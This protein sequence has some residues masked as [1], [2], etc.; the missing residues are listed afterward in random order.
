MKAHAERIYPH[1][2]CGFLLGPDLWQ[3]HQVVPATNEWGQEE[4][5]H[6]FIITA[7]AARRAE[8]A[9]KKA[10]LSIIGHYH[11]HPD[12]PARPSSGF[13]DSDLDSATWPGFAFVIVSVMKGK[14]ADVTCWNLAEDRSSFEAV[15]TKILNS[16][17][18]TRSGER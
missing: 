17:V 14:A 8:A 1:E 16:E 2:C 13:A 11:S 15:P 10:G 9:A 7:E 5:H 12:C 4:Q 18:G 6:R 3:V